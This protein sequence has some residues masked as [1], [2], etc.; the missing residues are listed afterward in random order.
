MMLEPG[1]NYVTKSSHIYTAIKRVEEPGIGTQMLGTIDGPDGEQQELYNL[2]GSYYKNRETDWDIVKEVPSRPIEFH[3][4]K[5]PKLFNEEGQRLYAFVESK[6][7]WGKPMPPI[8][9]VTSSDPIEGYTYLEI[10]ETKE[11]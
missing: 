10:Q 4:E 1:K 2:D 9:L 11:G 5:P 6:L 3:M 7:V 8:K